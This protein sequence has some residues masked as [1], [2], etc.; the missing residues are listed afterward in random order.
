L[1]GTKVGIEIVFFDLLF[2]DSQLSVLQ[3]FTQAALQ[4]R[5]VYHRKKERN[6]GRKKEGKKE[7]KKEKRK[8]D[9]KK[10]RGVI[11]NKMIQYF[12]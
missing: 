4:T 11:K 6:E 9:R 3:I 1:K 7:G 2:R 8:K 10:D 5:Y 12:T